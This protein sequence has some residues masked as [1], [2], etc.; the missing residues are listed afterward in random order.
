MS[1]AIGGRPV[2]KLTN[3]VRVL[4]KVGK[5][6]VESVPEKPAIR[7]DFPLF[8]F[9]EKEAFEV[10]RLLKCLINTIN[11]I[12]LCMIHKVLILS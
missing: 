8:F 11:G 9:K 2:A 12:K 3:V 4:L 7:R 6:V 5:V 1:S 10:S